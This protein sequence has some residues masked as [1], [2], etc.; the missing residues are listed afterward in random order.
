MDTKVKF[1]DIAHHPICY[2]RRRFEDWTLSQ[3]KKKLFWWP[4]P[5][6]IA[7]IFRRG[8]MPPKIDHSIN[9]PPLWIFKFYWLH[10]TETFLRI[11]NYPFFILLY[12]IHRWH[13]N[14]SHMI[15]LFSKIT[16]NKFRSIWSLLRWTFVT[17]C[18]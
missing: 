6:E 10:I 15:V 18:W 12:N 4:S 5:V 1:P 2:V 3:V 11:R 13:F 17:D 14:S 7:P 16:Y 9:I 8:I